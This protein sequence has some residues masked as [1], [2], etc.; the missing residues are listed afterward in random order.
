MADEHPFRPSDADMLAYLEG[1]HG[2]PSVE[3]V[4]IIQDELDRSIRSADQ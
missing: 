4:Q 2:P 3:A 1:E